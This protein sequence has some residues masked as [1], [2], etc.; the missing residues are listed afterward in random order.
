MVQPAL[1]DLPGGALREA[2]TGR[3]PRAGVLF[4]PLNVEASHELAHHVIYDRERH[5][6]L[7]IGAPTQAAA[8]GDPTSFLIYGGRSSPCSPP[9][10][11]SCQ[12]RS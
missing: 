7:P 3:V 9:S 12:E 8:K 1:G 11:R 6:P 10:L 4:P 5:L 2:I